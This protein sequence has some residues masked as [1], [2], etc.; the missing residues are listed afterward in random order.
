MPFQIFSVD[1]SVLP[2]N[3][4]LLVDDAFY[5]MV[6]VVA[7]PAEAQLL[8]FQGIR[9]VYSFLNTDDVFGI[10]ALKCSTLTNIKKLICFEI[11]D[12]DVNTAI[13]KPGCRS[14]IRYLHQ[15]LSQRHDE[16]MKQ[17]KYKSSGNKQSQLTKNNDTSLNLSQDLSQ[18]SSTSTTQQQSTGTSD[19]VNQID[20]RDFILNTLNEWCEKNL[21][22]N[23]KTLIENED[24]KLLLTQGASEGVCIICSC[25]V[26][27]H[28]TRVRQHFSL[29]KKM[30]NVNNDNR[31]NINSDHDS[32]DDEIS[33][34]AGSPQRKRLKI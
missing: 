8:E 27:F 12:G 9:G 34:A 31:L 19:V 14:N 28:L 21:K 20:H 15:L 26:K 4:L 32:S 30:I 22:L 33:D 6:E 25:Q 3:V 5:K 1:T 11:D 18:A 2:D 10:L 24:F 17:N 16:H 23:N 13:I 29:K 7:G